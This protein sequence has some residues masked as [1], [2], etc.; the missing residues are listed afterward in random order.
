M[1]AECESNM[2]LVHASTCILHSE[3]CADLVNEMSKEIG[4]VNIY[5]IYTPCFNN[6]PPGSTFSR[7]R[8]SKCALI[9]LKLVQT[10]IVN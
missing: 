7:A 1:A 10:C 6:L 9:N 8:Y 4:R 2:A 5:D 3:Q